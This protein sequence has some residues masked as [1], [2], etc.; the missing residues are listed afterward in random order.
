MQ[1]N[2]CGTSIELAVPASSLQE[3]EP[4]AWAAM[5][6]LRQL[7]ANGLTTEEAAC[8]LYLTSLVDNIHEH[9]ELVGFFPP[10]V[11]KK[12]AY[13]VLPIVKQIF[14]A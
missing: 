5:A 3:S 1:I 10:S 13:R 9:R 11:V 4:K 2:I 7:T 8:A 6:F 12:V 14:H